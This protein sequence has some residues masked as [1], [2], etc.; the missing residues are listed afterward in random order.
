MSKRCHWTILD[1][2]CEHSKRRLF[3][4][5]R[6]RKTCF[7][8]QMTTSLELNHFEKRLTNHFKHIKMRE[9]IRISG[10][11]RR[12]GR[13]ESIN[14][15][16]IETM[17]I[18]ILALIGVAIVVSASQLTEVSGLPRCD[19]EKVAGVV[20]ARLKLSPL[21]LEPTISTSRIINRINLSAANWLSN[22]PSNRFE[23]SILPGE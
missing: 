12:R 4:R 9:S 13:S 16:V 20:P 14:C 10:R 21:N 19:S 23:R 11:G 6:K 5:K 3:S 18:V 8:E 22:G 1:G 2:H 15:L 17:I 7:S